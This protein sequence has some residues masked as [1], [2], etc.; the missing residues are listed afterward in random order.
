MFLLPN[1][2]L[3]SR[4][5]LKKRVPLTDPQT[6]EPTLSLKI[7]LP[8]CLCVELIRE[9]C[10]ISK[11][12]SLFPPNEF[13]RAPLEREMTYQFFFIISSPIQKSCKLLR[14][15]IYRNVIHEANSTIRLSR[16][17]QLFCHSQKNMAN[18]HTYTQHRPK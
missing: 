15:I 8:L 7:F 10:I 2:A 3:S 1:G 16:Y 17:G 9:K 13:H 14:R 12:G 4:S 5:R 11:N 6:G 18:R